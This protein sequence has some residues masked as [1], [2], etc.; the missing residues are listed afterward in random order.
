LS[1]TIIDVAG[2]PKRRPGETLHPGVEALFDSLGVID[3]IRSTGFWRHGGL[4]VTWEGS[5]AFQQYGTD[6]VEPWLGFQAAREVLDEVLLDAAATA[7]AAIVR[8]TRT[9]DVLMDGARVAGVRSSRGDFRARWTIDATGTGRWLVDQLRLEVETRSVPLSLRFG[10]RESVAGQRMDPTLRA[11][12]DGWA[13]EA[14]ITHDCTAWCRLRVAD[15]PPRGLSDATWRLVP[16]CA[17]AGY[18]VAGDAAA[19]L[20]P[21]SSHGVLRAMMSGMLSAHLI[22]S[23]ERRGGDEREAVS[24]YQTWLNDRFEHDAVRLASLYLHHPKRL[25]VALPWLR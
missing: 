12:D 21:L 17:G 5:E 20:D 9:T 15:R 22:A 11:A 4:H 16:A 8:P 7:G 3:Q 13:W 10:W 14:P 2:R 1:V 23:I 25:S 6:G 18:F 24:Y 19:V